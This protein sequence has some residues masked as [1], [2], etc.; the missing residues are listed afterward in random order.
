MATALSPATTKSATWRFKFGIAILCLMV[1]LWLLLFAAAA[2]GVPGSTIA[3][4]T[5]GLFIL[6]KLL[7]L[8]VIAVMGKAGF[9]EL[10]QRVFG[11]VSGLTPSAEEMVGPTRHRIGVVMFALPLVC[12]FLEPYIDAL[13]PGLRPNNWLLQLLGDLMLI[14]SFFVLGGNFWEK[15]RALF[16]RTARVTNGGPA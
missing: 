9:G 2:V 3:A 6:N 4:I 1:A 14:G 13:A 7:L 8:L 12:S 15:L 16:I 11:Y 5:G 10:K